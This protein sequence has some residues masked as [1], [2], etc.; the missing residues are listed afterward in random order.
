VGAFRKRNARRIAP[1]PLRLSSKLLS[2]TAPPLKGRR[3]R[4]DR[5][6]RERANIMILMGSGNVARTLHFKRNRGQD[7]GKDD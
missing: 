2:L 7:D 5:Y 1:T 4:L 6:E 3:I